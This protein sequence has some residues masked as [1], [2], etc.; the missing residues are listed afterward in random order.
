VTSLLT[1]VLIKIIFVTSN[2]VEPRHKKNKPV[3]RN[4][5]DFVIQ[6]FDTYQLS[7]NLSMFKGS[8]T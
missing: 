4:R 6:Y 2:S 8:L 1:K 5:R 7:L 3:E